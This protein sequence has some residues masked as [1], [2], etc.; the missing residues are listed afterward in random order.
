MPRTARIA[1]GGIVFHVLNRANARAQVFARSQDYVAFERV[2][3]E[4]ARAVPIRILAYVVMPNHWHLVLWPERD[5][6]LAAFIHRLAT[7]HV[8][9]WHLHR[10]TVG[11]GHLYQGTYKSFPV[12]EDEHLL[13]VLRYVER[14]PVRAKLVKR[15]EDWRWSSL[16]RRLHPEAAEGRLALCAWPVEGPRNWLD[17]VNTCESQHQLDTLRASATKGRPF[18]DGTWQWRTAKVLGLESAF[19][20]RGRPRT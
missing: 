15:A 13:V 14:N 16:W 8:R 3:C 5:G 2:L 7:T 1:P 4:T 9:R 20:P 19:R 6:E 11:L 18:G 12:Q 17:F 10:Q